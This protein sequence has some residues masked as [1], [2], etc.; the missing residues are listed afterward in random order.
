MQPRTLLALLLPVSCSSFSLGTSAFSASAPSLRSPKL[1]NLASEARP[2]RQLGARSLKAVLDPTSIH[3]AAD[4]L[5]HDWQTTMEAVQHFDWNIIAD[6]AADV[7]DPSK[8]TESVGGTGMT[9]PGF[10]LPSLGLPSLPSVDLWGSWMGFL[11]ASI[12]KL[13]DITGSYGAS[14]IAIVLAVKAITY[15]LN[16]K[17]YAAQY[18]MQAI[19]PEIDRIK[20]QYKDNP[21]LVNMRTGVLFAEKEVNPL[22]GCLPILLQ[23]PIFVGLY[24]TLLNLGR[25]RTLEEPFLFLPS[26]EGPVVAGLPTDYVGVREDAP[27]LLQNWVDGTP[28]LGWHDTIVY[29]TI[30]LLIVVAQF[31]SSAITKAGQPQKPKEQS[32]DGSAETLVAVLP[33]VIGWFALNLPSGCALYWLVNTVFTTAQQLYI[34]KQL[35]PQLEAAQAA[36]AA[37]GGGASAVVTE[38]EKKIAEQAS[39]ESWLRGLKAAYKTFDDALGYGLPKPE[40]EKKPGVFE[41]EYWIKEKSEGSLNLKDEDIDEV[42]AK[43]LAARAAR[44]A[45]KAAKTNG[46]LGATPVASSEP[47]GTN[48]E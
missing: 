44:Q 15:P 16:Y 31:A 47:T 48:V 5:Q 35:A 37:A 41:K 8:I 14:I 6:A 2:T 22:A 26:L 3:H 32:G 13:H 30:P 45:K 42:K 10:E 46:Q 11:Q 28:P 36:A 40:E 33:Y 4:L 38:A 12:F 23:F 18:E 27:W 17:V 25:D 29:C 34:K 7:V 43:F 9:K 24:R 1:Q 20:E 19:Q 21:E 39:E